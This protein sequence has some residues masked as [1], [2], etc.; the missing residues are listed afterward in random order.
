MNRSFPLLDKQMRLVSNE[1]LNRFFVPEGL[2][3]CAC[4]FSF[5]FSCALVSLF[6]IALREDRGQNNGHLQPPS[7]KNI[8]MY[9]YR[10]AFYD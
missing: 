8:Q 1:Y 10:L 3:T 9:L 6:G 5:L 2:R 4:A 7:T